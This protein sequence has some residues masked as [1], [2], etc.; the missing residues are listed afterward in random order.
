MSAEDR[1]AARVNINQR[2][3]YLSFWV[4]P[5]LSQVQTR[6]PFVDVERSALSLI[7]KRTFWLVVDLSSRQVGLE[8]GQSDGR[9][10]GL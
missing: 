3:G 9:R 8:A 6:T 7:K 10:V 4:E 1:R 5:G 2:V